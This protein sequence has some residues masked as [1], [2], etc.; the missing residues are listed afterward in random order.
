KCSVQFSD[1]EVYI[2][3]EKCGR[4]THFDCTDSRS[5]CGH[6]RCAGSVVAWINGESL[7]KHRAEYVTKL[8]LHYLSLITWI[9]GAFIIPTFFA[10][11]Y[12]P[13][14]VITLVILFLGVASFGFYNCC[15]R[16]ATPVSNLGPHFVSPIVGFRCRSCDGP[17]A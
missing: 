9:P 13:L 1:I 7:R 2:T 16:C 17:N 14:G 15:P 10:R 11:F 12:G 6:E 3:C 8:W 4:N 5:K